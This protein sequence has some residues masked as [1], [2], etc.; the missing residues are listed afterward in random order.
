MDPG[1]P[2]K[3]SKSGKKTLSDLQLYRKVVKYLTTFKEAHNDT[4]K[5]R[6]VYLT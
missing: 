1:L 4:G 6:S 2:I 3:N 5:N